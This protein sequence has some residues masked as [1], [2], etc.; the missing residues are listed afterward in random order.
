MPN[1][2]TVQVPV[3]ASDIQG[4]Q[5]YTEGQEVEGAPP[6]DVMICVATYVVRDGQGQHIGL[7]R[8][9]NMPLEPHEQNQLSGFIQ[10][11]I[12]K[13]VNAHEGTA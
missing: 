9:L 1:K 6:V 12:L 2:V 10:A 7:H 11:T 8:S 4:F 5:V 3:E 13:H